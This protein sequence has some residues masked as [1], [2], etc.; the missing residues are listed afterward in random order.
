MKLLSK[1]RNTLDLQKRDV[2]NKK[3]SYFISAFFAFSAVKYFLC[4][5]N[6]DVLK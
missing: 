5:I 2:A 3:S 1:Q 4:N 6:K